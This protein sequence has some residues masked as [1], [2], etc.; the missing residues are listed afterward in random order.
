MLTE[1]DKLQKIE[2]LEL[3]AD[4]FIHIP[5]KVME[6]YRQRVAVEDLHEIQRHPA[7]IRYTLL[8][9]FCWQ[10][11]MKTQSPQKPLPWPVKHRSEPWAGPRW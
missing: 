5:S 7:H 2:A 1:I 9:A 8:A 3:P 6:S 10:E 4:L 11:T